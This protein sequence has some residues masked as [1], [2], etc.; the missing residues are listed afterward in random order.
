MKK[1]IFL[2]IILIF[3]WG[4]R[5]NSV[6]TICGSDEDCVIPEYDINSCCKCG[7]GCDFALNQKYNQYQED[8]RAKN[9]N[10]EDYE[11]CQ[12]IHCKLVNYQFVAKCKNNRC[13]AEKVFD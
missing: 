5:D 7:C 13:V 11:D 12:I 10:I 1:Y 9:C 2:L 6:E 3:L 8:W 4:C